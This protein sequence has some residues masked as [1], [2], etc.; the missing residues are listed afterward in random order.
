MKA[1][2]IL[3][4]NEDP[5]LS[6][7]TAGGLEEGSITL[8]VCRAVVDSCVLVSEEEILD[9]MRLVHHSKQWLIEGAA[10]VALAAY[11]KT[12]DRY[13]GKTVAIVICG[14][15]LSEKVRGLL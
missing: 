8:D 1:G 5:T 14:G 15:N 9:A 11:L 6:E 7:S 4:V 10:G 2:R 3:P 13:K 12:A